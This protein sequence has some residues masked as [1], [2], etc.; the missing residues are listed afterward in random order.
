MA[1]ELIYRRTASGNKAWESR[2]PAVSED[3][4]RILGLIEGEVHSDVVRGLLRR[5][6]DF[7]RLAELEAQG[8]V[9]SQAAASAEHNLDFTGAFSFG[10]PG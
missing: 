2:D 5:H 4:R 3:H 1:R 6:A 9:V 7:L 10:K 8:L